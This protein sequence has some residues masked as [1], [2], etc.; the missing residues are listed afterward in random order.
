MKNILVVDDSPTALFDINNKL[1]GIDFQSKV[2]SSSNFDDAKIIL[3]TNPI[4]LAII[5]LQ[6]P[7]KNGADLIVYMKSVN[8]LKDIPIIVLT[9]SG[10]ESLLRT[11]LEPMVNHYLNKPVSPEQ[12]LKVLLEF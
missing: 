2:F 4:D 7:E 5:D 9:G 3:E 8:Q 6:M 1:Q 12:L 11:S 10:T